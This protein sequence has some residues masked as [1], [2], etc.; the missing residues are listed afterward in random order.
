M[1]TNEEYVFYRQG[2]YY[3]SRDNFQKAAQHYSMA[4]EK[5]LSHP[6]LL[7]RLGDSCLAMHEFNRALDAFLEMKAMMPDNMSVRIKLAHAYSLNGMTDKALETVNRVLEMHPD[8]KT[9]L[10]WKARILALEGHFQEAIA[11][12]Y[13]VLGEPG[14]VE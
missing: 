2:D 9:A 11:I 6:E 7:A 8:W 3:Y 12:Y 4:L 10:V 1:R 5:G 14:R 13:D